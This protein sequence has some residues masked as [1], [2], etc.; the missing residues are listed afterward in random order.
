MTSGEISKLL[1]NRSKAAIQQRICQL[2]VQVEQWA[3][4]HSADKDFFT[5]PNRLNC[6]WAGLIAADGCVSQS[7][8]SKTKTLSISLIASD[9]YLLQQLASDCEYTG[10]V[11]IQ[12]RGSR[13]LSKILDREIKP[14]SSA[15][16][17]I[18]CCQEWFE[19][20][21]KHWNIIP[22][23]SLTLKPPRNLNLE[24]SLAYIKGFFDGDGCAHLRKDGNLTFVF[25][26]TAECLLWIKNIC[27][28][29]APQYSNDWRQL[30][31][32]VSELTQ[33]GKIYHYNLSG[34]RVEQLAK[35]ILQFDLPA[36]KRKWDKIETWLQAKKDKA[37]AISQPVQVHIF[38]ESKVYLG[39]LCRRG[40]SYQGTGQSLRRVGHGSCVK[41]S[42]EN[43]EVKIPM[44]PISFYVEETKKLAPELEGTPKRL[45][46]LCPKHPYL[47]TGY[48][49]V[50]RT[51]RQC[52]I[53]LSEK[54]TAKR[55]AIKSNLAAGT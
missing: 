7:H 4:K 55:K 31:R 48:S 8:N 6:Y 11:S 9:G 54:S 13:K 5:Q 14:S 49:L 35:Q 32:A 21:E 30:Q 18:S 36:M 24:C 10:S 47:D 43:S 22:R 28:E 45:G 40:H 15:S 1:P 34:Y 50:Y 17:Q 12:N 16:L 27:D 20:L 3:C 29:I 44:V 42:Q 53:C 52:A 26:G 41:C 23:K 2:G 51:G 19:D 39:R 37:A 46:F 25:Y 38:D 33:A